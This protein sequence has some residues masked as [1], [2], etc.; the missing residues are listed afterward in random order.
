MKS[1][2]RFSISI[3]ANLRCSISGFQGYY[4]FRT[5]YDYDA[6]CVMAEANNP[7]YPQSGDQLLDL[8]KANSKLNNIIFL[9]Q[10]FSATNLQRLS[11]CEHFDVVLAMNVLHHFHDQWKN[12]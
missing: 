3:R 2:D 1:L 5:A 10:L 9:N 4:S 8:C 7:N 12:R 6:V 11:E